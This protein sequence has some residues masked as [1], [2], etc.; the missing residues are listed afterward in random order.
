M[1]DRDLP[2]ALLDEAAITAAA[3]HH[4]PY[5]FSF[6]EHAIAERAKD[7][8]LADAPHIPD[9]GSYGLPSL[10]YGPCF[11]AVVQDL[12]S[13]RFRRLVE[14]KF[15]MDLSVYPP[16][17]VMMGNTTGHYNEGYAHPDSKHK[18]VTVLL[19]FSHAWPYERGRLRILRSANRED[20]AFEYPPEFGRMLMF[21]VCDHSWHGFLPQKGERMSLQLCYVDS[22]AYVRREYFRHRVSAFAKS[23]PILRKIIDWAPR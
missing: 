6:V 15:D 18:I 1:L 14:Q 4:D 22:E 3:L 23:V 7:A 20:Y 10:R 5:D 19:G 17:I 11:S 12:L 8:V 21:R 16:V 9:R 2:L 13:V